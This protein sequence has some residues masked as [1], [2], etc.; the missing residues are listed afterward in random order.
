VRFIRSNKLL[1]R[2][3]SKRNN[4]INDVVK[5]HLSLITKY[6]IILLKLIK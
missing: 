1:Y 3:I 4:N 5:E 2:K 6:N